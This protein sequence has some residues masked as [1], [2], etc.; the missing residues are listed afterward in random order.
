MQEVALSLLI[1]FI[2]S[3]LGAWASL[4]GTKPFGDTPFANA[5][6]LPASHGLKRVSD[7]LAFLK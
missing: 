5:P 6:M 3:I 4:Q 2:G 7:F 1:G